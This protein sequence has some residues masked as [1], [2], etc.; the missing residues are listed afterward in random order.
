MIRLL[1]YSDLLE[2]GIVR[3]RA[4]LYRWI[5][6]GRFPAGF[7]MGENTRLWT[8]AEIDEAVAAAQAREVA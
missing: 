1:R 4:T 3:N 6:A 7:K 5:R 2:R 8:E